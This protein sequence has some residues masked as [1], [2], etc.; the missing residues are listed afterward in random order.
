CAALLPVPARRLCGECRPSLLGGRAE[1]EPGVVRE[2]PVERLG[3]PEETHGMLARSLRSG[4]VAVMLSVAARLDDP[5]LPVGLHLSLELLDETVDRGL[6]VER[7]PAGAQRRPLREDRRLG[8]LALGDRRVSLLG[9]LQL[10]L[11]LAGELLRE[12]RELSLGVLADRRRDLHVLALHLKP[13]SCL[14]RVA[15]GR[16]SEGN[17]RFLWDAYAFR[18]DFCASYPRTP[19]STDPVTHERCARTSPP[20]P[21]R[22]PPAEAPSR[23]PRPSRRSYRRRRPGPR[24]AVTRRR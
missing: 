15:V 9:E 3:A 17:G 1:R 11:C 12:L 23:R 4:E 21:G 14:L 22:L 16:F 5:A 24:S 2:L 13:H 20:R 10:D 18:S 6:H 19:C 8:H 7:R